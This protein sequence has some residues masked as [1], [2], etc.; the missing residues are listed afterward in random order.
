MTT[1]LPKSSNIIAHWSID[2]LSGLSDG[3]T[4]TTWTDSVQGITA[5][6]ID[7]TTTL[8][9]VRTVNGVRG[10][11]F[12]RTNTS[13]MTIGQPAG[14]VGP[15]TTGGY[16]AISI[17]FRTSPST[18]PND[19]AFAAL[20]GVGGGNLL[21]TNGVTTYNFG[22]KLTYTVETDHIHV[23]TFAWNPRPY[24]SLGL[25]IHP[26]NRSFLDGTAFVADSYFYPDAGNY[27]IANLPDALVNGNGYNGDILDI[28]FW[29]WPVNADRTT[30]GL[31]NGEVFQITKW[32]C[33]KYG[34]AYPWAS[35]KRFPVFSGDSQVHPAD[36]IWPVQIA[37][38]KGWK[39]G[40]YAVVGKDSFIVQTGVY[41]MIDWDKV[42]VDPIGSV[43]GIPLLLSWIE[44]HNRGNGNPEYDPGNEY[45]Y[46]AQ[47][48]VYNTDRRTANP[49]IKI[50]QGTS[51]STTDRDGPNRDAY[52]AA[53]EANRVTQLVD[54]VVK[55][56][57]IPHIGPN[58][59]AVAPGASTY[60]ADDIHLGPNG[61][62]LVAAK[63]I[64]QI[65]VALQ[66]P[67]TCTITNDISGA[68]G[69][70]VTLT[71]TLNG[72]A[73]KDIVLTPHVTGITGAFSHA[74]VTIAAG[75]NSGSVTFTPSQ[76]GD[77]VFSTTN[78]Y[79]LKDSTS[80]FHSL[81]LSTTAPT[82]IYVQS[83]ANLTVALNGPPS[84]PVVW[85]PTATLAGTFSPESITLTADDYSGTYS[86]T[87]SEP[88]TALFSGTNDGDFVTP[89]TILRSV[90]VQPPVLGSVTAPSDRL[91]RVPMLP[92]ASQSFGLV[93][94]YPSVWA[95]PLDPADVCFYAAD[96][97][98][99]LAG[100]TIDTILAVTVSSQAASL[101]L[102]V[103]LGGDQRPIVDR[104]GNLI[105]LWIKGDPAQR[106]NI[107]FQ[108][109]GIELGITIRF[110]VQNSPAIYERTVAVSVRQL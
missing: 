87:P 75:T 20:F 48:L 98:E 89:P 83:P 37:R 92:G 101:G 64:E 72:A 19:D 108:N 86:F 60:F 18:H 67:T 16:Y 81:F 52:N 3:A 13:G 9:K 45:S 84:S 71:F 104:P 28:I 77:A 100:G 78:D 69:N 47:D 8:P 102:N 15:L 7:A 110:S 14:L 51:I 35:Q 24:S 82:T 4:T 80:P 50:I 88:G 10:L 56:E 36:T 93:S 29:S 17:V 49:S 5:N 31:N 38:T 66:W 99:V 90:V 21:G 68:N 70:P 85:T 58:G 54:L 55:C 34:Q 91:V 95:A 62:A 97:T 61:D 63:W 96:F 109:T 25:D 59:S 43:V 6:V 32:A 2:S 26:S 57:E 79:H 103:I 107:A 73:E 42:D 39:P 94:A 27:G 105:G 53:V 65:D 74:K 106:D 1:P 30:Q 44:W 46:L 40:Q 12:T 23:L 11:Q 76:T 33:D 41:N 22:S